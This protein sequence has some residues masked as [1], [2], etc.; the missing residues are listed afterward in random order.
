M[1]F[2][3][4][5][6]ILLFSIFSF[7]FSQ[8][9]R[10][11]TL[12]EP[13]K[14]HM[15]LD[16]SHEY[17]LLKIPENIKNKV[18][19][20]TTSQDSENELPKDDDTLFSDPDFYISKINKY[21]SSRLSSEWYSQRYGADIITIPSG[22]VN[23]GDIFYIGMYCQ[24]KCRYYLKSYLTNELTIFPGI[25]Y[26]LNIRPKE[27]GN[28]KLSINQE[29]EELKVIIHFKQ[30]GKIRVFMSKDMPTTQ[31]SF[32]V[33]P[34]WVYGYS[35]IVKKDSKNY[36]SNCD[37]H[38]FI[39]NEGENTIYNLLIMPILQRERFP[40]R[41]ILPLYETMD[42]NNKRC[43]TFP[44]EKDEKENEKLILQLT[45]YSGKIDIAF[46]GWA[47]KKKDEIKPEDKI[48][49]I[50]DE[51][52]FLFDKKDF[53]KYD[54]ENE[55]FKGKNSDFHFCIYSKMESSLIISSYFLTNLEHFQQFRDVNI[56]LPG[57]PMRGYLLKNQ[58]FKYNLFGLN[59]DKSQYNIETN[60]TV[61]IKNIAGKS[62]IYGYYCQNE[63]C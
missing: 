30:R 9:I 44:I 56:L 22:S 37:Y 41:K 47:P 34:S 60:I 21:P 39:K 8:K 58:V 32:N 12:D 45:M 46:E 57:N 42:K 43:Y 18:L 50:M 54:K 4:Y 13:I 35:I 63:K 29:F 5:F 53:N 27:T 10:N 33:V 55:E 6:F 25:G 16:E 14:G 36:C 51:Q 26:I 49:N 38:I 59:L 1:Y 15:E 23:G 62:L 28:L 31:N 40:L 52:F 17:F 19:V 61:K 48:E 24:F 2:K 11:I 7:S 20:F 3:L